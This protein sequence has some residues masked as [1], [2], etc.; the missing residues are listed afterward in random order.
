V[1]KSSV[2][3]GIDFLNQ[4]FESYRQSDHK[5]FTQSQHKIKARYRRLKAMEEESDELRESAQKS[6][7]LA[8]KDALTDI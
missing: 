4:H 6:R 1:L 3:D 7:D 2:S 8:L 5:R